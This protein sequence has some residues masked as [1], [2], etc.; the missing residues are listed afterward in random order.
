MP[1]NGKNGPVWC[2]YAA[3]DGGTGPFL[4]FSMNQ[5]GGQ[6]DHRCSE[7]NELV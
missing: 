6:R 1:V 7:I 5:L 2:S 3:D 4:M